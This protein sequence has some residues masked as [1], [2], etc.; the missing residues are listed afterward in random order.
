M[1]YQNVM[2]SEGDKARMVSPSFTPTSNETKIEFYYQLQE[3]TYSDL[4]LGAY[5]YDKTNNYREE[6][7]GRSKRSNHNG[8]EALE[9]NVFW[10]SRY[11]RRDQENQWLYECVQLA[12]VEMSSNC[13]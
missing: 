12:N 3:S 7:G 1:I 4:T 9:T 2:G 13:K 8:D 10:N 11:L 5:R 6:N